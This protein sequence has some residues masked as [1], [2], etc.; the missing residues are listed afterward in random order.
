[1]SI[2]V[3]AVGSK[4]L[5]AMPVSCYE[6]ARKSSYTGPSPGRSVHLGED[7]ETE[8]RSCWVGSFHYGMR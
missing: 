4:R 1:M 3:E 2:D 8:V 7:E 5:C 6:R